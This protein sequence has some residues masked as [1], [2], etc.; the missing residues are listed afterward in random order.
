MKLLV[1]CSFLLALFGASYGYVVQRRIPVDADLLNDI[2]N[3]TMSL[4]LK[5][6][7]QYE[8]TVNEYGEKIIANLDKLLK[9]GDMDPL[10]LDDVYEGYW[11][12]NIQLNKMQVTG[13]ATMYRP[14]DNAIITYNHDNKQLQLDLPISFKDLKFSCHFK[15][16]LMF[17]GPS[18]KIT[19]EVSNLLMKTSLVIDYNVN[20]AFIRTF[21]IPD[22]GHISIHIHSF[23]LSDWM[24][25]LISDAITSIFHGSILNAI[26]GIIQDL[27]GDIVDVLNKILQTIL[28]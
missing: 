10:A 22:S 18:G 11:W 15:A 17:V 12:G 3:I 25:N 5:D 1:L 7:P 8:A 14:E 13:L 27:L 28:G 4:T 16:S 23:F 19:G 9:K 6:N 21:E 24:Y 26:S 20:Q 2:L